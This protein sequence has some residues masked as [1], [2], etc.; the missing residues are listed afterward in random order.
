[1]YTS[2]LFVASELCKSKILELSV[3]CQLNK[4]TAVRTP[5][6]QSHALSKGTVAESSVEETLLSVNMPVNNLFLHIFIHSSFLYPY[7]DLY[8]TVLM[9][10]NV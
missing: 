7:Y 2:V 1:M 5:V 10:M 8:N 3:T 4:H 9:K 6:S